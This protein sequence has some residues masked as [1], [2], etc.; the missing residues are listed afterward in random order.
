MIIDEYGNRRFPGLYRG[1][2]VNNC[3]PLNQ[4]RL[5]LQIPQV[6]FDALTDWSP[7]KFAPGFGP[8]DIPVG[9]NVWVMFEGGDPSFPVW[10]GTI[11]YVDYSPGQY[12]VPN[13]LDAGTAYSTYGGISPIEAGIFNSVYGGTTSISGGRP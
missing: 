10:V 3:D 5:K 11:E 7:G 1:I 6:L 9:T 8:L 4:G 13:N 12:P 2:V